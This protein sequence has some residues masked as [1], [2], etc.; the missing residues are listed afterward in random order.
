MDW[1]LLELEL[2]RPGNPFHIDQIKYGIV[3][4][5]NY[6]ES[7]PNLVDSQLELL[8]SERKHPCQVDNSKL[9]FLV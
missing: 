3:K 7:P 9:E 5:L 2:S 1:V 6:F 8:E 4:T